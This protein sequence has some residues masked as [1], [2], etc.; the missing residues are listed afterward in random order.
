MHKE[1]AGGQNMTRNRPLVL[2]VEDDEGITTFYRH[3]LELEG[4][5]VEIAT[6]AREGI[7]VV[8]RARPDAAIVDIGIPDGGLSFIEAVRAREETA[9]L[10]VVA[11]TGRS[12]DDPMWEGVETLWDRY[13]T[14]PVNPT[15]LIE[16]LNHLLGRR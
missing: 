13:L 9:D 2:V 12:K 15:E 16:T 4:F 5:A 3:L 14:K 1:G 8:E 7:E 6:D 11:A 10:K